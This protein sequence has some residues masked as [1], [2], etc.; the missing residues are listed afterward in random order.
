LVRLCEQFLNDFQPY[1][2]F[3]QEFPENPY[4]LFVHT[5]LADRPAENRTKV[6]GFWQKCPIFVE[7]YAKY[8]VKTNYSADT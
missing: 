8:S 4:S 1:K 6:F 3:E 7:K 2:P 5:F